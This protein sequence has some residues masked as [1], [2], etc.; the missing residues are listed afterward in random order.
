V[1]EVH[2]VVSMSCADSAGVVVEC[3]L[4]GAEVTAAVILAE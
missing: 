4:V 1:V 3:A 2:T